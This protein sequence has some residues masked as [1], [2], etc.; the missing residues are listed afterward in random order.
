MTGQHAG[1]HQRP[2]PDRVVLDTCVL[3]SSVLRVLLLDLAQDGW[4]Q[5]VWSHGI[6]R[7]WKRTVARLWER[8][9]E[10]I[11]QRWQAMQ[12]AFPQADMGDVTAFTEGLRYTASHDWHVV[13]AGRA[14]AAQQPGCRVAV[15]TRNTR[16]FH[17]TEM[18]RLNLMLLDPDQFL[19]RL[20]H[21][22][23]ARISPFVTALPSRAHVAGKPLETLD[24]ML[25]RERLFRFNRL[26]AHKAGQGKAGQ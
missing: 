2:V 23:A 14:V 1:S 6:A 24:A 11:D 22:D 16:D 25:R 21:Q 12:T 7:E 8:S 4:Y 15:V 3:V 17:R 5:P 26:L 9:P 19:V 20:W 18:R 10:D 13:A